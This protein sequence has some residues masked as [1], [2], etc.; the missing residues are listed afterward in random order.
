MTPSSHPAPARPERGR[1]DPFRWV[2]DHPG[3]VDAAVFGAAAVALLGFTL[4]TGAWGWWLPATLPMLGAA[5]VCRTRPGLGVALM[6]AFALLHMPLVP[7]VLG[8]ALTFYAMFCAIA[9][10]RP[11]V[12]ALGIVAGVVGALVQSA[13]WALHALLSGSPPVEALVTLIGLLFAGT[14]ALVAVW[15][16]ANLQRARVQ[17]MRLVAERAEQ[18]EREREQ[19]TAL[20]VAG[21]R[22][23]I[24]R[25]MHDVVAHSLSVIIAQADGGRYVASV[26]PEQAADVLATIA[27]TGRSALAD[28]RSLLGVLRQ[29][30]ETSYG[31][32]PGP[33][34]LQELVARVRTAG[35]DVD[36]QVDG[37]L[38]DLPR[39]VGTSLFRLVQEALTNTLKHAGPRATAAVRV[40]RSAGG[41]E[42]E[43]IDDGQGTDPDS[44]G[45]GHGITG[46]RERMSVLGGTLQAGPLPGHGFR[47][48]ARIPLGAPASTSPSAPPSPN[49]PPHSERTLP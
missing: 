7:V 31:P 30:D 35:L 18:A 24:A 40:R 36:L 10:G 33:E 6:A 46:M 23:R 4:L 38:D 11:L 28:M 45:Q 20:A 12:H 42:V 44:D 39:S 9:Y 37:R 43:V 25:E 21:E 27:D 34:M 26:R 47:V 5:A 29:D 32:Q 49:V 19:R 17:Q 48:L 41:L 8:D 14:V 1:R 16:L 13:Y 2:I 15:A 3:T 22:S